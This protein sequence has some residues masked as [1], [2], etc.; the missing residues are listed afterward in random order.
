[1]SKEGDE[2]SIHSKISVL[3]YIIFHRIS[4]VVWYA[5]CIPVCMSIDVTIHPIIIIII[6]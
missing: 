6:I 5:Y 2:S 3:L 1:M 4:Y